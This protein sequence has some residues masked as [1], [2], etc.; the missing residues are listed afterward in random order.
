MQTFDQSLLAQVGEGRV[1]TEV[2]LKYASSPH[3]FKL[4]LA[5]AGRRASGIDQV[6][7]DGTEGGEAAEPDPPTAPARPAPA[8][9]AIAS[10][11]PGGAGPG[12]ACDGDAEEAGL[13]AAEFAG[14]WGSE[15]RE[16]RSGLSGP[17]YFSS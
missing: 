13:G 3:D 1:S 9:A 16:G 12:A 8:A 14:V 4:M 6:F 7:V 11:E 2:A 5:S 10:T 17:R 15:D